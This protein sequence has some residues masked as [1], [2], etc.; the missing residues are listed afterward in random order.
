MAGGAPFSLSTFSKSP[1]EIQYLLP[2]LLRLDIATAF[3]ATPRS[4]DF[5]SHGCLNYL[6]DGEEGDR[7]AERLRKLVGVLG[8]ERRVAQDALA[9]NRYENTLSE[10]WIVADQLY[11]GHMALRDA[12]GY[13]RPGAPGWMGWDSAGK[14][15][16][17]SEGL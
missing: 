7:W 14:T 12:C 1:R 16:A 5:I 8:R 2:L 11:F 10:L 4:P 6:Y 17:E 9:R 3:E 13:L 15:Q